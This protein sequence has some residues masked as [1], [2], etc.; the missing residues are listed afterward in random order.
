M[1]SDVRKKQIKAYM[2]VLKRAL[3]WGIPLYLSLLILTPLFL[4]WD[5]G[6]NW[7]EVKDFISHNWYNPFSVFYLTYKKWF[8]RYLFYEPQHITWA[9]FFMWKILFIPFLIYCV[10]MWWI[11]ADNPNEYY[12]QTQGSARSAIME[13]VKKMG[14]LNGGYF[15]LGQIGKKKKNMNLPDTRSVLCIGCPGSGKTASVIIPNVLMLNNSALFIY[16]IK[17]DIFK[18]TS[19]YRSTLGPVFNIDFAK[20]DEPEKGIFY[21]SW[22]PLSEDNLPSSPSGIDGYIDT[23]SGYLLP[24]GPEG[25]DPYWVISGRATLTGLTLYLVHKVE[26]AKANDYFLKKIKSR[27]MEASDYEI[28]K[29]YYKGMQQTKEIQ[30]AIAQCEE[31]KINEENYIHIGTWHLV[32]KSYIGKEASYGMLLD[33]LNEFVFNTTVALRKK[34]MENPS[35]ASDDDVWKTVL[36]LM[37]MEVFNYGYGRRALLELNQTL[38]LPDK[39]R[40]SVLSM[41]QTGLE[42][43]KNQAVRDR[44][45][46]NSFSYKDYRG[47]KGQDGSYHPVTFYF[48]GSSAKTVC[49][50]FI[51]MMTG[52]L[53]ENGPYEGGTGPFPMGFILDDF[54][55]MPK[56]QS[57]ADGICFGRSKKTMF[58]LGVQDWHQLNSV[59]GANT[60]N[61]IMSSCAATI[62][63][64]QNNPNTTNRLISMFGKRTKRVEGGKKYEY[65]YR[66][67]VKLFEHGGGYKWASDGLVGG[68]GVLKLDANK[69]IINLNGWVH[70]PINCSSPLFF[71]DTELKKLSSIP[72]APP[73]KKG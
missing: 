17:G 43:F 18:A 32:P 23:L 34:Q 12:L 60:T 38:S 13:D 59:Y 16:D 4:L 25:T 14:L 6:M 29:S 8:Y 22:N 30:Q 19:G 33:L 42:I 54:P 58:L 50:L 36:D 49:S 35:F 71:K 53:M 10:K 51:N 63:K 15:F 20:T 57:I 24:D 37:V 55:S 5:K 67:K 47:I 69:Q 46:S 45:S 7:W 62:I 1:F 31:L 26:Q 40:A 28:L 73:L 2:Y 3:L 66:A 72:P 44:T 56:L 27:S 65:G 64:R 9:S 39:Q 11:I 70:R 41:A 52:Y 48:T 21:P 68:T 61:I